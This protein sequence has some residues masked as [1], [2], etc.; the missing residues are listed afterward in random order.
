MKGSRT[1]KLGRFKNIDVEPTMTAAEY[2]AA[3]ADY[4]EKMLTLKSAEGTV[5][6]AHADKVARRFKRR[7]NKIRR[8][9]EREQM[10]QCQVNTPL[11]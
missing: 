3:L 6:E 8:Y 7:M 10:I 2:A 5:L 9:H 1:L 11:V 4:E